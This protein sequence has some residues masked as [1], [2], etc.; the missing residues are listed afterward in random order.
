MTQHPTPCKVDP[1]LTRSPSA[2]GH[3]N[4]D[5]HWVNVAVRWDLGVGNGLGHGNYDKRWGNVAVL[6]AMGQG[7]AV[8]WERSRPASIRL[9]V[10][11]YML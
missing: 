9:T 2:L 5:K 1:T 7:G 3:G 8:P 10:C 4:Y 6:R 11:L